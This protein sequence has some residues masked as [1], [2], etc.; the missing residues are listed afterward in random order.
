MKFEGTPHRGIDD[1]K[2]IARVVK[3]FKDTIFT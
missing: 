2:N 1:A 3:R